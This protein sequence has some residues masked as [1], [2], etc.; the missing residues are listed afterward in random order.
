MILFFLMMLAA[1]PAPAPAPAPTDAP[2]AKVQNPVV[3]VQP[4]DTAKRSQNAVLSPFPTEAD[5]KAVGLPGKI[6]FSTGEVLEFDL[7]A[8][9]AKAGTMKMSVLPSRENAIPVE[10]AVETNTFF[11]KIRRVKGAGTSYLNPKTLRSIRYH[12]DAKENEFH[13]VA[14]V[15]FKKDNVAK[16]VSNIDGQ[17]W[18]GDL[19]SGNDVTDVAGAIYML[20]GVPLKEGQSICF[21]VYGIRAIW[22][23]WGI[24]KPKEPA[25]LPIGEFQAIHMAGEAARLDIPNAR[26]EIHI[27]LSDDARRLPLA[28]LGSIDL[29]SVRATLKAFSRPGEKSGKA[30]SKANLKW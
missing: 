16:L 1:T 4:S 19:H 14:D 24:V 18:S 15:T 26:R 6:P 5:C 27:W 28:A 22:R 11:S 30:E 25:S 17:I 2:P 12:E 23:V 29:G 10:V 13:R 3:P 21:D 8:L 20:R 9:G 7:D